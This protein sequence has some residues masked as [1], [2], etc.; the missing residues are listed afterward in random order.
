ME[1]NFFNSNT[2]WNKYY[3]SLIC[4]PIK[5]KNDI[6]V[7]FLSVEIMKPLNDLI[8]IKNITDFLEQQCKIIYKNTE[9]EEM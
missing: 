3:Q 2:N 5:D 4:C 8:D 7:G 9:F 6:I 1:I